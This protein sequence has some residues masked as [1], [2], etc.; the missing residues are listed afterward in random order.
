MKSK[1][2]YI[3]TNDYQAHRDNILEFWERVNGDRM[4]SLFDTYYVDNP[5]G[6][7]LLGLCY[8][9]DKL[10]G[11]ENYIVQNVSYQGKTFRAQ[12][13]LDTMVDPDYRLLHGIFGKLCKLTVKELADKADLLFSM[14]NKVSKPYY[15]KYFKWKEPTH[16]DVFKKIVY[17]SGLNLRSLLFMVV[18]GRFYKDVTINPVEKFLPEEVDKMLEDYRLWC[19]DAYFPK[20]SAFLNWKFLEN[21][22]YNIV[23]YM[24]LSEGRP[25]GYIITYDEDKERRVLDFVVEKNDPEIFRKAFSTLNKLTAQQKISTVTVTATPNA[26][27]RP[28][29]SKMAFFNRQK[30]DLITLDESNAIPDSA[31]IVNIGDLDVF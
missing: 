8:D 4:T 31:W 18:P 2:E 20:T 15:L 5:M 30:I 6:P 26:W 3:L 12:M 11:T 17:P 27:Y 28:L 14:P 25:C 29:L 19:K 16:M 21:K 7:P 24:I 10:V 9:G 23:G 1:L 22:H 13:G